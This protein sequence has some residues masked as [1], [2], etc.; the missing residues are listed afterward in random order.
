[1][2]D[3]SN[4]S[5]LKDLRGHSDSIYA[6]SFNSDSTMLASGMLLVAWFGLAVALLQYPG[7]IHVM[8]SD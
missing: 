4:G 2:W 3:L 7:V 6:L 1:M 5:L 8:E